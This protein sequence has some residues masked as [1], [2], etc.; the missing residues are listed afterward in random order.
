MVPA[1]S[2]T[3][4]MSYKDPNST[5]IQVWTM[6]TEYCFNLPTEII[7]CPSNPTDS[8]RTALKLYKSKDFQSCSEAVRRDC[9]VI[10]DLGPL[11]QYGFHLIFK[12][13][14]HRDYMSPAAKCMANRGHICPLYGAVLH[15]SRFWDEPDVAC[16]KSSR[17]ESTKTYDNAIRMALSFKCK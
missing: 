11:A 6:P 10:D 17:N 8:F 3:C 15:S 13:D 14:R 5:C 1:K 7:F 4:P 16:T 2:P 9:S 12:G